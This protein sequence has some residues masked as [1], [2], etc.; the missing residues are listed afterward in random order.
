MWGFI[1]AYIYQ[2]YFYTREDG[3]GLAVGDTAGGGN[4]Q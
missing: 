4:L 2:P 3:C 1:A